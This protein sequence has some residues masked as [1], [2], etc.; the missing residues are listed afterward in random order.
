MCP[1]TTQSLLCVPL[2][3]HRLLCHK[4]S[5]Q[6]QCQLWGQSL[7]VQAVSIYYMMLSRKSLAHPRSKFGRCARWSDVTPASIF[8]H[9]LASDQHQAM[10]LVPP[11][12]LPM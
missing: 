9:R 3:Q 5:L 1:G 12:E 2:P 4:C 8:E 10:I 11:H 7:M 6:R